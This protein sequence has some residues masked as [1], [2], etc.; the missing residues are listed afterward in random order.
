MDPHHHHDHQARYHLDWTPR[1][2]TA[3]DDL[4]NERIT[5][6]FRTLRDALE[7]QWR[8]GKPRWPH[9]R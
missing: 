5:R 4:G 7:T 2:P 1:G 9:G 6:T 3:F 8:S